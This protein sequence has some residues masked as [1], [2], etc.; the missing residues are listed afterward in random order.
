MDDPATM[1]S[2]LRRSVRVSFRLRDANDPSQG[3]I[4]FDAVDLSQGGAF[5]RSDLLLEVGEIV[6][7]T[8]GLPGEIRPIHAR[9]RVAWAT[10]QDGHKGHAGMGLQFIELANHDR[11]AIASFIRSAR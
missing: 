3:D 8:F 11:E 9:A 2:Y 10:R 4:L 7:V 1:R 5:L 6:D